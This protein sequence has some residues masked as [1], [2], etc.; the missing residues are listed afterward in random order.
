MPDEPEPT[1]EELEQR[2]KKLLGEAETA[3]E[4]ELDQ[5]ELKLREVEDKFAE[6]QEKRKEEE[7]LFDADFEERLRNLHARAEKAKNVEQARQKAK[8]EFSKREMSGAKGAGVGLTVAYMIMGL[9]MLGAGI[10]WLVDRKLGTNT[11][12][13][14][15]T[16]IG[17]VMGV[18]GAILTINRANMDK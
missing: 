9:P 4:D 11:W 12:I 2:L 16:L 8:E 18:A 13:G 1:E 7:S 5:I 17:A 15:G 6:Q 10:G 14:F 3:D